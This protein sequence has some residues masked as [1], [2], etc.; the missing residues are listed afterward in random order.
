M[1]NKKIETKAAIHDLIASRWS[2]RAYDSSKNVSRNDIISLIEA[3]RWAPSCYGD[4]PWRFIVFDKATN[5]SSW[6]KALDCLAEGNR[7]WAKD[8]PLLLLSC[9][10][11]VLS[12]NGKPNRW[13][14]YDTGAA[15]ENLCL[16]AAA[17]GLMVH[18]MGGYDA[19]KTR[20]LFSIPEQFTPMAM[21]TVGYQL[22]EDDIP[23][24]IKEREYNER[25]RNPI[26]DNFFEGSWEHPVK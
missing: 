5:E 4:Q 25:A 13:A 15:T 3:A 8:A 26:E 22:A 17:L 10:D 23:E 6:Q 19:D 12:A 7:A 9:S 11:S 2:G 21:M 20:E 1:F 14:Q 24:D 18:Q 16:Q